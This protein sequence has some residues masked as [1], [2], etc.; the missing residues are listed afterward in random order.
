MKG[1]VRIIS[2]TAS[3]IVFSL[4][5]GCERYGPPGAWPYDDEYLTA[6]DTPVIMNVTLNDYIQGGASRQVSI[7]SGSENL[8]QH[9]TVEMAGYDIIKYTPE[10]GFVGM[11]SLTYSLGGRTAKVTITVKDIAMPSFEEHLY[12][13]LSN[14]RGMA[15]GDMNQD[16]TKDI[17]FTY[18]NWCVII[19]FNPSAPRNVLSTR[20]LDV[21]CSNG[22][23]VGDLDGDG[24]LDIVAGYGSV[25]NVIYQDTA[26]PNGFVLPPSSIPIADY[27]RAVAISDVDL[28]GFN[29]IVVSAH[30]GLHVLLCDPVFPNTFS[31]SYHFEMPYSYCGWLVVAD[32]DGDAYDDIALFGD[33]F[34]VFLQDISSPGTFFAPVLYGASTSGGV[35]ADLNNDGLLDCASNIGY[36]GYPDGLAVW[37]QKTTPRGDFFSPQIYPPPAGEIAAGDMN[38]DGLADIATGTELC[39]SIA[40]RLQDPDNPG[41]FLPPVFVTVTEPDSSVILGGGDIDNDGKFDLVIKNYDSNLEILYGK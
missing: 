8:P 11:D 16:G 7:P 2:A 31:E 28:D 25:L 30:D 12:P 34:R 18:R 36:G 38:G 27:V 4:L 3:V 41:S 39:C 21:L 15:I 22:I 6:L 13:W 24:L 5:A 19:Y 17:V 33:G 20:Y 14:A 9:G 10:P 40:I 26:A 35:V 23:A 32:L 1:A 29:D 37:L